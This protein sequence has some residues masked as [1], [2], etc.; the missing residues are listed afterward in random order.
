M[1]FFLQEEIVMQWDSNEDPTYTLLSIL[2][3]WPL[4]SILLITAISMKVS[5]N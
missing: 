3:V 2:G 5:E 4:P 1:L